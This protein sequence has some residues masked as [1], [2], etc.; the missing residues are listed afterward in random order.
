MMLLASR[1]SALTSLAG[2]RAASAIASK[3]SQAVYNAA[4]AKSPQ[5]L[6][7]VNTEL[8]SF[9]STLK[10]NKEIDG[11]VH[12][13]TLSANDRAAGL[14]SVFKSIDGAS[15]KEPVSDITKNLLTVLSENGRLAEVEGVVQ[16]LNELVASYNGELNVTVT[17]AT[18]LPKDILSRIETTLKQ[19]QTAQKAKTLKVSNKVR[20]PL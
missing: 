6:T 18:P 1:S 12:N 5:T 19:S 2:R 9:V 16:G 14:A 4:L 11:F 8:T 7:K 10:Q 20:F 3:Y 13:P 17:S 15:K